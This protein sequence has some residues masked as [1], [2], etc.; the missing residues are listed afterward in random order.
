MGAE[1]LMKALPN[2]SRKK[3]VEASCKKARIKKSYRTYYFHFTRITDQNLQFSFKNYTFAV[4]MRLCGCR[5]LYLFS[6]CDVRDEVVFLILEHTSLRGLNRNKNVKM[7]FKNLLQEIQ[8]KNLTIR[9][10]F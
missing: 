4:F 3:M 5:F 8:L 9:K 6:L 7:T 10:I 2:I 1:C